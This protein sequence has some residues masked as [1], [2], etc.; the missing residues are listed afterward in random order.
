[1]PDLKG[2]LK[3]LRWHFYEKGLQRIWNELSQLSDST[4]VAASLTLGTD[5]WGNIDYVADSAPD[6]IQTTADESRGRKGTGD[7]YPSSDIPPRFAGFR[8]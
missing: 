5:I 3:E 6:V 4:S 2:R 8:A 7:R 1:M